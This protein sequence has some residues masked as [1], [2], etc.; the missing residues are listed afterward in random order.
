MRKRSALACVIALCSGLLT[1]CGDDDDK[2][3]CVEFLE[4]TAQCYESAGMAVQVNAAACDNDAY[5]TPLIEAQIACG[6]RYRDTW[7]E[8]IQSSVHADGGTSID[9]RDPDV[10]ALNAC[11]SE[12]VTASPCK[13]AI[14]V[15]ADCGAYVGFAPECIESA[16]AIARCIVDNPE[17]ACAAFGGEGADAGP[18]A[19][20]PYYDCYAAAQSADAG[21][22]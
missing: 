1:G 22:D 10:L 14:R 21:T 19:G 5:M 9:P 17:A 11:I 16:P 2:S 6:N 4:F 3:T 8:L 13:E 7:C 12:Q 20:Q 15:L 18:G